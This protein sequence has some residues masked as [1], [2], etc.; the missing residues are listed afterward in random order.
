MTIALSMFAEALHSAYTKQGWTQYDLADELS[1]LLQQKVS[2][3]YVSNIC[4]STALPSRQVHDALH[5][6]FSGQLPQ[7]SDLHERREGAGRKPGFQ[8]AQETRELMREAKLKRAAQGLSPLPSAGWSEREDL[9]P[10]SVS[11]IRELSPES[12]RRVLAEGQAAGE[13]LIDYSIDLEEENKVLRKRVA[14]L[15]S[16]YAGANQKLSRIGEAF[17]HISSALGEVA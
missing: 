16:W 15:E 9:A 6:L 2:Q 5:V 8:H 4:T 17:H 14:D 10:S 11:E 7:L 1:S 12:A 3:A 13:W